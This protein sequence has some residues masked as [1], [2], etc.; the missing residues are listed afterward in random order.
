MSARSMRVRLLVKSVDAFERG[1]VRPMARMGQIR[2]QEAYLLSVEE[3]SVIVEWWSAVRSA[4]EGLGPVVAGDET[5]GVGVLH[6]AA[7]R[8]LSDAQWI[9]DRREARGG[10]G[11]VLTGSVACWELRGLWF[12]WWALRTAVLELISGDDA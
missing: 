11:G 8:R 10:P 12:A 6:R 2:D 1:L 4:L 9:W 7:L 5:G 3:E